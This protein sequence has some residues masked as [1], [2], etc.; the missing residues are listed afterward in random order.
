MRRVLPY[1]AFAALILGAAGC[2]PELDY[3]T[4]GGDVD[5]AAE[6][7]RIQDNPNMPPQAREAALAQMRA[8]QQ[9][10][11]SGK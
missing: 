4:K 8:H 6:T 1:V 9:G 3:G 11:P 7:K 2:N 10:S 5:V